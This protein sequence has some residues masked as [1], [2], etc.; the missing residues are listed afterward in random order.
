M[1]TTSVIKDYNCRYSLLYPVNNQAMLVGLLDLIPP[2]LGYVAGSFA[3]AC[4]IDAKRDHPVNNWNDI[5]IFPTTKENFNEAVRRLLDAGAKHERGSARAISYKLPVGA[6]KRTAIFNR[7][8]IDVQ[9]IYPRDG[10]RSPTLLVDEFDLENGA[11]LILSKHSILATKRRA[12]MWERFVQL[13]PHI[14]DPARTLIRAMKYQSKG[15]ELRFDELSRLLDSYRKL[16]H[17]D[18]ARFQQYATLNGHRDVFSAAQDEDIW[19]EDAEEFYDDGAW[20]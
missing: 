19:D 12:W 20:Y 9:V 7:Q 6:L 11:A 4:A 15:Y 17:K 13:R 5:D 16:N 10:Y 1:S 3:M 2:T 8:E 14:A 18:R